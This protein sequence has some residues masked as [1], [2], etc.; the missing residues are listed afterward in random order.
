MNL[1]K[2]PL[3]HDKIIFRLDQ[4][5]DSEKLKNNISF[6]KVKQRR[7]KELGNLIIENK[8]KGTAL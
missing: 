3:Q 4:F 8:T 5:F 6:K 2:A 1:G 7:E